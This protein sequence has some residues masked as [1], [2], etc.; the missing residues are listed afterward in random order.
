MKDNR[1]RAETLTIRLTKAEKEMIKKK[2]I[3]AQLSV[4]DFLVAT[5][6]RTEI[7]VAE[8]IKPLLIELKRIGNN[9]NQI[10]MK[11]NAGAF[12]SADFSEV[13][14]GQRMIFE[15]LLRIAGGR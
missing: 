8:D 3:K 4:T 11:I 13:I 10:T 1:K 7:H 15:Q 2:A 9:I 14:Q 6:L 12:H 5:S